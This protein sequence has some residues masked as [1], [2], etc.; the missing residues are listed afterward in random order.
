MSATLSYVCQLDKSVLDCPRGARHREAMRAAARAPR[1]ATRSAWSHPARLKLGRCVSL[2]VVVGSA[3]TEPSPADH[4]GEVP[5]TDQSVEQLAP[6]SDG[7]SS[8]SAGGQPNGPNN[9]EGDSGWASAEAGAANN[10]SVEV[11]DATVDDVY[12]QVHEKVSTVLVVTWTQLVSTDSTW[13]EFSFEG[14]GVMASRP[15]PG[16]AGEHRDVVLGVP[17]DTDVTV[18]IVSRTGGVIA[19]TSEYHATT[20]T[21]PS[22]MPIPEVLSYDQARSSKSRWLFGSVEDSVGGTSAGYY[23]RTFWLYIMD[24][25]GRIVWYYADPASNATS[26]FQRIARDGEYIWIEKRPFG[27]VGKRSVVKMTLDWEY[28]EEIPVPDLS[29]CIDVTDDG[30]LLFDADD[31]LREMARDGTI[32]TIWSCRDQFGPRFRC[33]SNTVNWYPRDDTIFM[34]FPE[35]NTVVEIDRLSGTLR[36]QYGNRAGSW[37]FAAPRTTPPEAWSFSFQHFP[38][39]SPDDTLMVSTHMPGCSENS[40]PTPHQHAF[41]QFE[42]D[43]DREQLIEKWRYTQGPEWP[44]AKGMAIRLTNGNTLANYGTGGVIREITP[45]RQTVFLVKFD[46]DRGDD[47]YNKMVGNNELIDDLYALN[48]GPW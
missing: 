11:N 13:L 40:P 21:V 22:G 34:S 38:N 41:V 2:V 42:V 37:S 4:C 1:Q 31:E 16:T 12:V 8:M 39:M 20:D 26:S 43:R 46:V 9:M 36:A 3:C 35:E 23:L 18:R 15:A 25:S 19:T 48:G 7:S 44:R 32:R 6:E 17:G 14:S 29:D 30:S 33:Y 24:R 47:F 28:F 27:G 10:S 5:S 45:D